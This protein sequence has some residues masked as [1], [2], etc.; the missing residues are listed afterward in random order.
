MKQNGLSQRDRSNGYSNK[1][2][3]RKRQEK[4]NESLSL[5]TICEDPENIAAESEEDR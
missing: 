1:E 2:G 3:R 4:K 5:K